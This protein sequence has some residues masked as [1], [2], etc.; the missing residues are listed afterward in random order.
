MNPKELGSGCETK[1]MT[2][3]SDV[4]MLE[5]LTELHQEAASLGEMATQH[6]ERLNGA[7]PLVEP[8]KYPN[9]PCNGGFFSSA[10]I[11]IESI[12][13]LIQGAKNDIRQSLEFPPSNPA[14]RGRGLSG[15]TAKEK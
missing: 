5:A 4:R 2:T 11:L 7:S 6:R 8:T 3:A 9:S 1:A 12:K 15:G 10:S 14:S 13:S